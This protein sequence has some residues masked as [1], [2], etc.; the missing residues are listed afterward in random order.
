MDARSIP[1][2][3]SGGAEP[4]LQVRDLTVRAPAGGGP[5]PLLLDGVSFSVGRGEIFGLTGE[6]G[7][8]KSLT[9]WSIVGLLD[10]ALTVESGQVLFER[11][12]LMAIPGHELRRRRGRDIAVVVQDA[13]GALDPLRTIGAQLAH[14]RRVHSAATRE[15]ARQRAADVLDA[16]RL[17]PRTARA[18]PHELSGGMAQRAVLAMALVNRA[19]LVIADEP[20]TGLDVTVQAGILD[21]L[22]GLA[23][24]DHLS[25]LMITHDLGVVANYCRRMAVMHA[26]TIVEQGP[27]EQLFAGPRHPYTASLLRDAQEL[28]IQS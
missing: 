28:W 2:T 8:G 16:V 7:A 15:Q 22:A 11:D 3:R 10:P 5:G 4:L 23:E 25:V 6:T 13:A 17:P 26:G 12:D 19:R 9:G 1:S 14:L 18:Y 21:L 20:T 27:V 24:Q